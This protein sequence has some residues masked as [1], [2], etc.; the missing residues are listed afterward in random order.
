MDSAGNLIVADSGNYKI[1][2][3]EGIIASAGR[4]F[5]GILVVTATCIL[6][7]TEYTYSATTVVVVVVVPASTCV[8]LFSPCKGV[9]RSEMWKRSSPSRPGQSAERYYYYYYYSLSL[10]VAISLTTYL[11]R[12]VC[13]CLCIS[14]C[15]L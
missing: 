5:C 3:V 6:G 11:Y 4:A 2:R 14:P 13:V 1:R 10:S 9:K 8:Y 7:T 12:K 15:V